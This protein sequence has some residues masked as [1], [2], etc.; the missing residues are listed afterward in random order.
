MSN[1]E[2][3]R[4]QL[5]RMSLSLTGSQSAEF[6]ELAAELALAEAEEALA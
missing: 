5:F 3:L 6:E 1:L 4:E 2:A